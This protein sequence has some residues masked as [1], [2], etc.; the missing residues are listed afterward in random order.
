MAD[1]NLQDRLK[2]VVARITGH[3]PQDLDREM[4]LEGDLGLDSI[5]TVELINAV[6][7]LVPEQKRE[8]FN[9]EVSFERLAQIQT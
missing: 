4:F 8:Q 9:V 3:R 7:E 1:V 5:K 6:I 2:A